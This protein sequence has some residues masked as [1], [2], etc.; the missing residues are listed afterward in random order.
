MPQILETCSL[1]LALCPPP[2]ASPRIICNLYNCRFLFTVAT[3]FQKLF[4]IS[5]YIDKHLRIIIR[6]KNKL[7]YVFETFFIKFGFNFVIFNPTV[8][9][10]VMCWNIFVVID[11]T[12]VANCVT[13]WRFLNGEVLYLR[14]K[15]NTKKDKFRVTYYSVEYHIF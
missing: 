10:T 15:T 13:V 2:T 11:R 1:H 12:A 9:R 14:T 5:H 3:W 7:Y 6:S 4:S 8:L